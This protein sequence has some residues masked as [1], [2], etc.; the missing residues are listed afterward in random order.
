MYAYIC[1]HTYISCFIQELLKI[2]TD[3]QASIAEEE[4]DNDVKKN[5]RAHVCYIY[6]CILM[7]PPYTLPSM[8]IAYISYMHPAL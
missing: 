7:Y 3:F 4:S 5:R 2:I 8:Y 6:I 1:I